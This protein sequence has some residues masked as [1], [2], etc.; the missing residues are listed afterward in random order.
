[1]IGKIIKY[2]RCASGYNQAQL[3]KSAGIAQTTLSGYETG[4]SNPNYEVVERIAKIC[5]F[6]IVFTDKNSGENINDETIK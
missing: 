4:Y 2:M 3:S 5:D 1:M 6:D